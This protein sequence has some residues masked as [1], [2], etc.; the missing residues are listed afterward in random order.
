M[1]TSPGAVD[2]TGW[3]EVRDLTV[4][5]W[6]EM[7]AGPQPLPVLYL[8]CDGC[9]QVTPRTRVRKSFSVSRGEINGGT[10]EP[11]CEHAQIRVVDDEIPADTTIVCTGRCPTRNHHEV[12]LRN[13]SPLLC[14]SS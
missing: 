2:P 14:G 7:R 8:L 1:T 10:P 9:G 11:V 4:A 12:N 5:F 6:R 3:R 13:S